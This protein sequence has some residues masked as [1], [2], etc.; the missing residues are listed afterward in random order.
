M[1]WQRQ[2]VLA[3]TALLLAV[4]VVAVVLLPAA[5]R[6]YTVAAR[7]ADAG[8][9]V[10][11]DLVEV[12]GRRVGT[13][14]ELE[15]TDNGLADVV[16]TIDDDAVKPLHDGTTAAIRTV[17]LA[18]V[19]NRFVDA[20]ARPAPTP[21]RS[22][23]AACSAPT[24]HARRRRPRHAARRRRPEGAQ[25][26]PDGRPARRPRRSPRRRPGRSTPA[27]RTCTRRSSQAA[28]AGARDRRATRP[29]SG[30][31]VRTGA[32]GVRRARRAR[33]RPGRG[34]RRA[35]RR[36]C[37]RSP[38]SASDARRLV[39][40]APATLRQTDADAAAAD[41]RRCPWSTRC[42]ATCSR[43]SRRWPHLLRSTVAGRRATP[44]PAIARDPRAAAAGHGG[45]APGARPRAPRLAR[46]ALDHHRA[47]RA[48]CRSWP[49]CAPYGPDFI[50]GLFN[51]FGGASG[52]GYDA[53]GHFIRIS[54]QGAPSSLP[55]LLPTP[56]FS[57]PSNGYRTGLT[58]RCP[59]AAEEPAPD[60]SNPW[61]AAEG[62]CDP[63]PRHGG[64]RRE[65]PCP[66][67]RRRGGRGGRE[68][69]RPDPRRYAAPTS[70]YRVDVVF[71][72]ARGLIPGQLVEIAGGRVGKIDDV[73]VTADFRARIS[74]PVDRRFAPFRRRRA[75][76]D[77][78]PGPD[79]RELRPV[80]PGHPGGRRAA[81][82]R[83][84]RRRRCPCSGPPSRSASPT[85][86]RS[87]TS[88][89]ATA[90]PCWSPSWGSPRRAAAPTST[91]I[92][93]RANPALGRGPQGHPRCSPA[94]ATQL[95]AA[96]VDVRR[97]AGPRSCRTPAATRRLLRRAGCGA[98]A[99]RRAVATISRRPS[100]GFRGC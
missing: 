8:Q 80:R 22:P 10:S 92:L 53:N 16:L 11:G 4:A 35:P 90:W 21:R 95:A 40:R 37:A 46:A 91:A 13:V 33:A 55:G 76:H 72:N 5:A 57:F 79:R 23:T 93:R 47:A 12:G 61:V 86:S 70:H 45:P 59:G 81:R 3:L 65:P 67:H 75:L 60:G 83:R 24:A 100:T 99:D 77:P 14:T 7:F 52:G 69:A 50:G 97:G 20:V 42:C 82:R 58:A 19:T 54:L 94:S 2:R 62:L 26:H 56:D 39:E 6:A 38:P 88:R 44:S 85:S 15:L 36:R 48:C 17:G 9:L 63:G 27:W 29:R 43:R 96:I 71:D 25:R 78:P 32:G 64:G 34:P 73:S 66:G 30:R 87:G 68:P 89:R 1:A 84:G 74:L 31:L 28:A 51:G 41:P 49:G 18:S 98:D